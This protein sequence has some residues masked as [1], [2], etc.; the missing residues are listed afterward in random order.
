M[1]KD[2]V[3]ICATGI[4]RLEKKEKDVYEASANGIDVKIEKNSVSVTA[5][6]SNFFFFYDGPL[7]KELRCIASKIDECCE[8]LID[9][10]EPDCVYLKTSNGKLAYYAY[11]THLET[12]PVIFLHGGPGG[13]SNTKR[14]RMLCLNHPIYLYD[15]MGGGRS[16]KIKNI[17][18]WNHDSFVSE[19]EEFI[20]S[21]KFEKVILI[22]ASWG[23]GLAASYAIKTECEKIESMVLVSPFFSSRIWEEDQFNNLKTLDEKYQDMMFQ[24]LQ[25]KGSRKKYVRVMEEYNSRFLFSQECYREIAVAAANEEPPEV[26]RAMVG[27]NEFVTTGNM[28]DFDIVGDLGKITVPVLMMN[29]DSDEVRIETAKRFSKAIPECKLKIVKNAGHALA[30]E[31]FFEYKKNIEKFI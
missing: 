16:G 9:D 18:K 13:D 21:M 28:K 4:F 24:C 14:A 27:E 11:N 2:P 29:G 25:G 1:A 30:F 17:K 22:G 10:N 12:T 6:L 3:L 23:A 19:L 20:D 5:G 26:F 8:D 7:R 31:Q 15:Q